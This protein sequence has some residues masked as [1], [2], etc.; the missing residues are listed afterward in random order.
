MTARA[1]IDRN[2]LA[3][4]LASAGADDWLEPLAELAARR[5]SADG[6]GDFLRWSDAI[7][8]VAAAAGADATEQAL[9]ALNPWRKG[10]F[11]VGGV[12]IDAEWRSDLKWD[13]IAQAIAP[14]DD[15]RVLDV[16]CGNGYYAR[17]MADMGAR[18]VVGIDPTILYV[19]QFLAVDL[20][21]ARPGVVVLP[22]RLA[23]LPTAPRS[24]DTTVSMGVLY[25]Q[26]SPIDH[27]R[28]LRGTLRS[29]G[30]LVLETLYLPGED[31]FAQTP[32]GRYA[33]MKNVWLLPSIAELETW[34]AR[35]GY[36]DVTVV[37]RSTTTIDEQRRTEWMTFESLAEALDPADSSLTV[38][39]LP[40]PR[41]VV[42]TA[43][44][45]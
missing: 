39:G 32:P 38:E 18:V 10:P 29:G 30:Q 45:P 34:L 22:L 20:L 35:T 8:A 12:S 13:R 25:H 41:R 9:K 42:I 5:L 11:D 37:D 6:H 21:D 1:S 3:T 28:E 43:T 40:A 17:R 4:C 33:R 24:F 7:D 36:R 27:L 16:G 26:R 19:M 23:E 44:S 15:R 31:A 2:R 14:L